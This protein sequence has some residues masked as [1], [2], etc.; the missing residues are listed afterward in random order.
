MDTQSPLRNI[1]TVSPNIRMARLSNCAIALLEH[2]EKSGG[3]G[4]T[5]GRALKRVHVDWAAET[6]DWPGYTSDELYRVNKVL[7]EEDVFPL[8]VIHQLL[9]DTRHARHFKRQLRPTKIGRLLIGNPSR[10]FNEIVPRFLF[11]IDHAAMG[12]GRSEIPGELSDYLDMLNLAA[13]DWISVKDLTVQLRGPSPNQWDYR[14][15]SLYVN[16]LRPL[17]WAGLM[18][19]TEDSAEERHVQ[20]SSLWHEALSLPSDS[21]R[22][23]GAQPN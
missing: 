16:V 7:N 22:V 17:V 19:E 3:L 20:K 10:A 12:R 21:M 4:L 8:W 6:F 18:L 23:H 9:L 1:E 2:A 14:P 5:P 11:D 15:S 13:D